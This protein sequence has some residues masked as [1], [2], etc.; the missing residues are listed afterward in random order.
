MWAAF[1]I[2]CQGLDDM[3]SPLFGIALLT[4]ASCAAACGNSTGL[5]QDGLDG[6]WTYRISTVV[7]TELTCVPEDTAFATL[8]LAH[9]TST[10][11]GGSYTAAGFECQ[12]TGGTHRT[13]SLG[14]GTIFDGRLH[15]SNIMFRFSVSLLLSTGT[16]TGGRMQGTAFVVSDRDVGPDT[17]WGTWSAER[18][19]TAVPAGRRAAAVGSRARAGRS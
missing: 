10:T 3:T 2:G 13:G 7:G 18:G 15:G 9:E 5:G 6:T 12:G 4:G 17:L 8:T 1:R 14:P 16:I 19:P 11:F